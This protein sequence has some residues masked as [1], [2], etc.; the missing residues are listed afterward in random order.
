[1]CIRDSTRVVT[2]GG[3][4]ERVLLQDTNEAINVGEDQNPAIKITDADAVYL[5]TK[6]KPVS[7]THLQGIGDRCGDLRH[8]AV[9]RR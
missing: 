2:V 7:Y 4:K 1:M 5:V 9:S 8:G 3:Q 6:S